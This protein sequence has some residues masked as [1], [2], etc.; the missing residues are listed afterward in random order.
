MICVTTN[1]NNQTHCSAISVSFFFFK[2]SFLTFVHLHNLLLSLCLSW[3]IPDAS[4]SRQ[5]SSRCIITLSV[6]I[7][8]LPVSSLQRTGILPV[9]STPDIASCNGK[10]Q[11]LE[12]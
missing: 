10:W 7:T 6:A 3:W 2:S 1:R 9:C 12:G 5:L 11:S 8:R 4:A